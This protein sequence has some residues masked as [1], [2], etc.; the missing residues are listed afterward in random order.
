MTATAKPVPNAL[1]WVVWSYEHDAWWA[2][3]Q[4]G[5]ATSLLQA[6]LYT[7]AEAKAIEEGANRGGV[8]NE[9]AR[10]LK[11]AIEAERTLKNGPRVLDLFV[12]VK[13]ITY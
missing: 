4:C 1:T 6:G 7:E 3:N 8:R 11:D 12:F 13:D 9:E 5:Y 10:P 2:P